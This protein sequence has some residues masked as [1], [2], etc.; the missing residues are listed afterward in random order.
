[1]GQYF[2]I[3]LASDTLV[4]FEWTKLLYAFWLSVAWL[5]LLEDRFYLLVEITKF[6][7]VK[8]IPKEPPIDIEVLHPCSPTSFT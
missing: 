1:M 4:N 3:V 7:F 6:L 8:N 5:A 2:G